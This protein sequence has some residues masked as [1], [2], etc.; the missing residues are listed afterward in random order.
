M[1]VKLE[2]GV[3]V[4]WP[5]SEMAFDLRHPNVSFV[6]PLDEATLAQFGYGTYN[7]SDPQSHDSE[8]QE[9]QEATPVLQ[10][11]VWVQQWTIVDKYTAEE[12]TAKEDEIATAAAEAAATEYQL[13]RLAAYPSLQEQMDMLYWDEVNGTT[14]WKDAIAKVKADYPKP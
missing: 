8:W 3:P 1:L 4:E 14:T 11:G 6:M 12:R 9:A 2:N 5:V 10:G 7:L 13:L